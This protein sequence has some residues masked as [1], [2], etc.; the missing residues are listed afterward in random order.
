MVRSTC[1]QLLPLLEMFCKWELQE[2]CSNL[3]ALML[4]F[5]SK[6]VMES[7][8]LGRSL[9]HMVR[10]Q[11]VGFES[12]PRFTTIIPPTNPFDVVRKRLAAAGRAIHDLHPQVYPLMCL[13]SIYTW[14]TT[15]FWF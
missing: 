15:G 8:E 6:P 13:P 1:T 2:D 7:T 10:E 14:T 9:L 12:L 4:R 11:D 5:D 3:R